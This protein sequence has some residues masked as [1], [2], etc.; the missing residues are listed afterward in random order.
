MKLFK[1]YI[2]LPCL[3]LDGTRHQWNENSKGVQMD[4]HMC[5]CIHKCVYHLPLIFLDIIYLWWET[6][7]CVWKPL[8]H[9]ILPQSFSDLFL[10][11]GSLYRT[12]TSSTQLV[13]LASQL[14]SRIPSLPPECFKD[15]SPCHIAFMWVLKIGTKMSHLSSPYLGF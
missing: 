15:G 4:S 11:A 9:R 14:T 2:V 12:Q 3:A 1:Y 6:H 10:E 8:A 5:R 7:V 13:C